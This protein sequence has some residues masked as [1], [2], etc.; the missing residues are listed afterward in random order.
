MT[1][2][3]I[4]TKLNLADLTPE[5]TAEKE[6]AVS[7]GHATDLLSDVLAHAPAQGVLV[8]LQV[9]LNVIAVAVHSGQVGVIFSSGRKPEEEVRLKA[10]EEKLP[11]YGT[12]EATLDVSGKLYALG[13]RGQR[14]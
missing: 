10:V 13:I 12:A 5:L 14:P 8:T 2:R 1:L 7:R 9:H 3:E 6:V 4:A 11:L